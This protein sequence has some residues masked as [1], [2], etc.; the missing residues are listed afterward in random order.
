MLVLYLILHVDLNYS[1]GGHDHAM[2]NMIYYNNSK[3][4]GDA[5]A[6]SMMTTPNTHMSK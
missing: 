6:S 5:L 2:G 4:D 3:P 1:N